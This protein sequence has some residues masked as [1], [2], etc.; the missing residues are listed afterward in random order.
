MCLEIKTNKEDTIKDYSDEIKVYKIVQY[1]YKKYYPLFIRK[2]EPYKKG[3]NEANTY[4][5]IQAHDSRDYKAGFHFFLNKDDARD[6]VYEF[7]YA[8]EHDIDIKVITCTIKKEWIT[9]TGTEN[10]LSRLNNEYIEATV[11]VTKKAIFPKKINPL[12]WIKDKI[13]AYIK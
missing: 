2:G 5:T 12:S 7:G 1:I 10:I 13:C 11:I 3:I 8:S 9:A 4:N 6:K